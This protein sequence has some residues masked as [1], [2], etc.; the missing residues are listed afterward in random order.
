MRKTIHAAWAG[1]I[2][3]APLLAFLPVRAHACG[4]GE[5]GESCSGASGTTDDARWMLKRVV[6]EVQRDEPKA[7]DEFAHGI[8]GFRTM[9]LYVFCIGPDGRMDAHPDPALMG[10]DARALADPTG[11]HF[12]A[13]MLDSAKEGQITEVRYLFPRPDSKIPV[14]KTSF[15]TRVKDQVCGVGYY[16]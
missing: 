6:A 10:Q 12:A 11:K 14:P 8:R 2:L 4:D 5:A 13:E 15:V 7:L 3:I 16:D 1:A 9:D